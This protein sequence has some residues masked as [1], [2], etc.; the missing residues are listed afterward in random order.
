MDALQQV[1]H[2]DRFRATD[3]V[4]IAASGHVALITARKKERNTAAEQCVGYGED[5]LAA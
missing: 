3:E 1:R 2:V 5:E 4:G